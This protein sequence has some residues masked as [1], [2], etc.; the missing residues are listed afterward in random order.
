MKRRK[1]NAKKLS[2]LIEEELK[3]LNLECA[4]FNIEVS[5]SETF[6]AKGK[7]KV[8]FLIFHKRFKRTCSFEQNSIRG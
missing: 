5:L 2:S 8:E 3:A 4:R 1:I 6:G 7:N